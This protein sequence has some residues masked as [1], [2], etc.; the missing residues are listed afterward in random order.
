MHTNST[1]L[2]TLQCAPLPRVG[3]FP[4]AQVEILMSK[5][6]VA[7]WHTI[8]F[9]GIAM[10]RELLHIDQVKSTAEE[11]I[12]CWLSYTMSQ[13]VHFDMAI[14]ACLALQYIGLNHS[15]IANPA[16]RNR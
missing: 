12:N 3:I 11:A 8:S 13:P 2:T 7:G 4:T 15:S 10:L 14:I 6:I 16:I 9:I 1:A 5:P